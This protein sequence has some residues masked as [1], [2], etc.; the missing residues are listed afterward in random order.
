MEKKY[1]YTFL[2]ENKGILSEFPIKMKFAK[3]IK[4]KTKRIFWNP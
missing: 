1:L 2:K 3:K 4:I